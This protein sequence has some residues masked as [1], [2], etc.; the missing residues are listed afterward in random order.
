MRPSGK[1]PPENDARRLRERLRS[2]NP[3]L[4]L[5]SP[6]LFDLFNPDIQEDPNDPRFN[7]NIVLQDLEWRLRLAQA[8]VA[9]M[10]KVKGGHGSLRSRILHPPKT[11]FASGCAIAWLLAGNSLEDGKSGEFVRFTHLVYEAATG[12]EDGRGLRDKIAESRK[13]MRDHFASGELLKFLAGL[14]RRSKRLM[15]DPYWAA[16]NIM[17]QWCLT[18]SRP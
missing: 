7:A 14:G 15:R 3:Y 13:N 17:A 6:T 11:N 8:E 12:D 18:R 2:L 9:Q 16:S 4:T 5:L 10:L 1:F